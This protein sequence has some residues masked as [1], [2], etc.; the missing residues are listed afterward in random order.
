MLMEM[1]SGPWK[2][3]KVKAIRLMQ[4]VVFKHTVA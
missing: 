4:L 1:L 3:H 2:K